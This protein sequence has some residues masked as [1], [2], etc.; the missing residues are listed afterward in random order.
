MRKTKPDHHHIFRPPY[1]TPTNNL[2]PDPRTPPLNDPHPHNHVVKKLS[3]PQP[4]STIRKRTLSTSLAP[5]HHIPLP[6]HLHFLYLDHQKVP[7]P[8]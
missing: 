7:L 2:L 3:Q 8:S 4:L 5:K 6:H 1:I